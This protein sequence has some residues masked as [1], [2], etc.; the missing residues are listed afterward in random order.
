M[1]RMSRQGKDLIRCTVDLPK[2]LHTKFAIWCARNE[3]SKAEKLRQMV[4]DLVT[5]NPE[6]EC[7]KCGGAIIWNDALAED[8]WNSEFP[9]YRCCEACAKDALMKMAIANA[10]ALSPNPRK[11]LSEWLD[12]YE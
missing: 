1:E 2:S 9:G 3:V 8:V 12:K 5:Q 6:D 4:Q 10:G 7:C 11:T